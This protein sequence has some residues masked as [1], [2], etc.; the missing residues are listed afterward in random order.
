MFLYGLLVLVA[1]GLAA[2]AIWAPRSTAPKFAALVLSALLMAGGYVSLMEVLGRPK[3]MEVAWTAE[4][5]EDTTVVAAR[6]VEGEAIYLWLES[7]EAPV[8]RA[9]VLPW[10]M[11][12]AKQ[13]NEAT[14]QAEAEG[15]EVQMRKL[16]SD[17]AE[18]DEP[19]FYARPQAPLPDKTAQTRSDAPAQNTQ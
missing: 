12:N 3:P 15:T 14:R 2:V 19:L 16:S 7:I 11:E 1:T 6:F 9:Y 18:T 8:P 17:E 5:A 10:S 4:Q 13:L